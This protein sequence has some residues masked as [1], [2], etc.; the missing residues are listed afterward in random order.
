MA[1]RVDRK[2]VGRDI[3]ALSTCFYARMR[4]CYRVR[5]CAPTSFVINLQPVEVA[6]DLL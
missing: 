6:A 3:A 1:Q 5:L 4:E 2:R